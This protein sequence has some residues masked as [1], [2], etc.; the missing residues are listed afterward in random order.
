MLI[1]SYCDGNSFSGNRATPLVVNG[2]NLYFR[3]HQI[4]D[5]RLLFLN[6]LIFMVVDLAKM[7]Y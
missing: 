3:G 1:V 4:L 7:V 2:E 5:V 6:F